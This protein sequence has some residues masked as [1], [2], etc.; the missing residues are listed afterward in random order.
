MDDL[1]Q[2]VADMLSNRCFL[3]EHAVDAARAII[4]MV[5]EHAA[6]KVLDVR[7]RNAGN[8]NRQMA[9]WEA[10]DKATLDCHA[11]ICAIGAP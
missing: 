11:A 4:P 1:E 10:Y 2:R 7:A 3:P 5:L 6:Q 8:L 9:E